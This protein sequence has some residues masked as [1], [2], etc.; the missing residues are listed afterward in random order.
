MKAKQIH[1]D[2]QTIE[3][4]TIEAVKQKTTFKVLVQKILTSK[5]VDIFINSNQTQSLKKC[6]EEVL[7]QK[8]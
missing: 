7:K 4:L 8:K 1:L 2:E 3:V 6:A 5:A